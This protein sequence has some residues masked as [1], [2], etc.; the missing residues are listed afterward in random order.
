MKKCI[1]PEEL[2]ELELFI[3]KKG[4][5]HT[6][7]TRICPECE[8]PELEITADPSI[9][10]CNFCGAKWRRLQPVMTENGKMIN[11]PEKLRKILKQ[12]K[13]P[14]NKYG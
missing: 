4:K 12:N 5:I 3:D 10:E 7:P 9:F 8:E 13:K 1:P 11:L 6:P 2:V 14:K